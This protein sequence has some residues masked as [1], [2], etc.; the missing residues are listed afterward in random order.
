MRKR[1]RK[2]KEKGRQRELML[3]KIKI[4]SCPLQQSGNKND[5]G[6]VCTIKVSG[7]HS[8]GDVGPTKAI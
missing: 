5:K 1:K 3:V 8:Q 4:C 2:G 7:I 6:L